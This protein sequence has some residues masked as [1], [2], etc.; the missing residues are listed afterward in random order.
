MKRP[1]AAPALAA[2]LALLPLSSLGAHELYLKLT[3]Y[4]V[5]ASAAR[6]RVPVLNGTFTASEGGVSRDRVDAIALAG[7]GGRRALGVESWE[8]VRDSSFLTIPLGAPGSYLVGAT[9]RPRV[10]TL[11]PAAFA[12]YLREEGLEHVAAARRAAGESERPARERYAKHVKAVFQKGGPRTAGV[13]AVLGHPAELV[14]VANPYSLGV[15]DTLDVRCMLAGRPAPGEVAIAGGTL[16]SGRP[17]APRRLRAD[18]A[19]LVRV[20][21]VAPGRWYVRFIHI[22]R[23]AADSAAD[24]ESRWATLTFAVR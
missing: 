12:A 17:I 14:P 2:L 7:P 4:F 10:I 21:L 23:L 1:V 6:V 3:S 20:P 16:P 13:D 19:G 8:A 15:G 22:E 24:Y 18:A 11:Q 9:T 5:P